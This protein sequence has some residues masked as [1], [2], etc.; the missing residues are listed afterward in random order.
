[1]APALRELV[2]VFDTIYELGSGTGVFVPQYGPRRGCFA[3][4]SKSI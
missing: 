4:V 3:G 1:L 2:N